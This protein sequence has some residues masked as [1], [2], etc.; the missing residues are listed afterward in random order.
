M[1][2]IFIVHSSVD[3]R[4]QSFF[5]KLFLTVRVQT[6]WA[7]YGS[8]VGGPAAKDNIQKKILDS[9]ALFFILSR[10]GEFAARSK[11]W[12][13]W[14]TDLGQDKDI[15]VFEH[16]EDLRRI[17]ALIPQ[18]GHYVAYYITNAWSDYVQKIAETYEKPKA[19]RAVLP[20]ASWK[21]LTPEEESA[22]FIPSTGFALFDDSTARPTGLR[23]LCPNCSSSYGL[24]IPS[25]MKVIRCPS[26]NH[27]YGIQQRSMVPAPIPV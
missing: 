13:P 19:A 14:A 22:Y 24:H 10:D 20:E 26:C 8:L 15:W 4:F 27:F 21:P 7:T 6:V 2:Q 18:L 9:D 16:C 5:S 3:E 12:F 23:A 25:E 17:P 11:D 1:R